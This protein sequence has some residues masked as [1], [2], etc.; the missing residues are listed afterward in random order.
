MATINKDTASVID[1]DYDP[2]LWLT[3]TEV[4]RL[5]SLQRNAKM[6][7]ICCSLL[8]QVRHRFRVKFGTGDQ[9]AEKGELIVWGTLR[10][11]PEMGIQ[12]TLECK[13]AVRDVKEVEYMLNG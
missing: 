10:F 3:T 9:G 6:E 1:E 8:L 13:N 11:I 4:C 5:W 12:V 2:R 7:M